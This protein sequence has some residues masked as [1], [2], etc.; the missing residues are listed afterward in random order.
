MTNTTET[1]WAVDG[2]SLQTFAFN[3]TTLG[4][5]RMAPPSVRGDDLR[6]PYMPGTLWVPRVPDS[7]TITLGM[8][9]IGANEDGTIPQDETLRR[10]FDRNWR[11]LR[12]L[13]WTPRKQFTLTKRF[14]LPTDELEAG[15]V[16]TSGLQKDGDWALYTASAR[17]TYA[18]GLNPLMNGAA[19]ANFTVDILL[20]DPYF[21][22][23]EIEVAFST[24]TGGGNPGPEQT[25]QVLGDDR[26]TWIEVDFDGPL[27]SPRIDNLSVEG[28]LWLR[29][30]TE[31][32]DGESAT[33]RVHNFSATHYTSGD[34]YRSSGYVQHDGDKFW[35]YMEPGE[36]DL[37]LSAQ[38]GTGE[39]VLR[40]KPRWF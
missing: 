16:D 3:I 6:V 33:V 13:L 26:T 15:G 30:G 24:Q 27:T 10:T 19:R 8:W 14:W 36:T 22:S 32:L 5:D 38:A 37:E 35:L 1:Y 28:T 23:D 40:Y 34:D 17:G 21:Y 7:R 29:Y 9:V 12:S 39:A 4:G 2:V 11:K 18:G 20:S 31:I 25:L